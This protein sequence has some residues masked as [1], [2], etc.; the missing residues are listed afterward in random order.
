ME[1]PW[2]PFAP[3]DWMPM[4]P[5]G[6]CYPC[7]IWDKSDDMI[8]TPCDPWTLPPDNDYSSWVCIPSHILI[9]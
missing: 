9:T 1:L 8:F 5:G 4:Q 2:K 6:S 7:I 3:D